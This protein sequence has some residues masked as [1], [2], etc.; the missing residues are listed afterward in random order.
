MDFK[1]FRNSAIEHFLDGN[2]EPLARLILENDLNRL[3]REFV[4]QLVQGNIPKRPRGP[5]PSSRKPIA[6][7]LIR[8]WRAEVDG[9]SERDAI[10]RD[11][12][13][14]LEVSGTMVRKYLNQIDQPVTKAQALLSLLTS[15]EIKH[16]RC[17][18]YLKDDEMI[19][20]YR[21]SDL[22]PISEE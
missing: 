19:R 11:I 14:L 21:D 15:L 17:A 2:E 1:E 18:I 13:V 5:K 16:R 4:A 9:W 20:L 8:F 7:A 22:K 3:E 12:E 10:Q 6:A